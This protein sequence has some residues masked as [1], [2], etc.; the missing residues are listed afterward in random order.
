MLILKRLKEKWFS[1]PITVKASMAYTICGILQK[2]LS[3]ISIPIFTRMLT[4]EQYGQCTVYSSWLGIIMIFITL[5]LP[6]GSFATAMIKYEKQRDE[7]IAASEGVCIFLLGIF[8][9]FYLPFRNFW[10]EVF[11]MP[12]FM[13]IIMLSEILSSTAILL[14]SGKKRFEY[15]Y[16][17]VIYVTLISAVLSN[18]SAYIFVCS[19]EEKGYAK[20]VGNSIITIIIGGA[21]Y[22]INI[23]KGRKI[24]SKD[25]WSFIFNFNLPLIIYYLAQVVFNQSDRIMISHYC[26]NDKAGMYG[27][28][29]SLSVVLVFVLNSINNAYVPWFYDKLKLGI[30]KENRAIANIISVIMSVLLLVIIWFAPEIIYIMAGSAYLEAMWVVPPITMSILLLFYSQ[31]SINIEFYF[32]ENKSLV[33]A[34]IGASV[35]NIVLNAIFIPKC[36][37]II[38]GYTTLIS[39]VVFVIANYVAMKKV[40][41]KHSF[42]DEAYDYKSLL[43]ILIIFCGI[44]FLG[45]FLYKYFYIRILIVCIFMIYLFVYRKKIHCKIKNLKELKR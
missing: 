8:L 39:Y 5:N 35:I 9:I 28:A 10:N 21:I 44:S 1:V 23:F 34:S 27:V 4:T 22:L 6:Y 16:K 11:E 33:K 17:S 37:F 24:F 45:V 3:F 25:M 12:T 19:F 18:L 42:C 13:I 38:A 30:Q 2:C 29:Y 32:E 7:Y 15:K 20:I 43:I 31:L 14:W 41:K 26:G 36:G 40:L